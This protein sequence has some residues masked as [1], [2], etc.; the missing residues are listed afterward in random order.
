MAAETT[1]VPRAASLI[2]R[3]LST[4]AA[5]QTSSPL[6]GQ[7]PAEIRSEIFAYVLTDG[8]DHSVPEKAYHKHTCFTRPGYSAPRR[9]DAALLRTCRAAY[10]EGWHLPFA[11]REQV[12]WAVRDWQ[13][14]PPGYD[15][16]IAMHK[17]GLMLRAAR[18]Q[19]GDRET[20]TTTTT[21]TTTAP[22]EIQS[23]R[24]FAQTF[25][26]E[27]GN[28]ARLLRTEDLHPRSLTLT[29]RHAD[30][31][32]WEDDAPLQLEGKWL[33]AV[34]EVLS[35]SV[36]EV[37]VE[38]ES[39]QRKAGQA[40]EIAAQMR[41]KWWFRRADGVEMYAD[42][43]DGVTTVQRW[44]GTSRWHGMRWVRDES[45]EGVIDYYVKTVVFRPVGVLARKGVSVS[46][47]AREF[48][49][50]GSRPL[51]AELK[52]RIN[53]CRRIIHSQP[54]VVEDERNRMPIARR[55]LR[56]RG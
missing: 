5:P 22:F 55:R 20:P 41:D 37:R 11:M 13:R 18:E 14:A 47:E 49:N 23:L 30:W 3:I 32:G 46:P 51:D 2:N 42:E 17:M 28:L 15:F 21:T 54:F 29:V 43:D 40:D 19:R 34:N 56:R 52:L 25:M 50:R 53:E 6:F 27:W 8:P 1:P 12:H 10:G 45:G 31:L 16:E 7:L 24:V 36:R 44:Q 33:P 35:S 48:A 4:P 39:L 38:L 9:T 26:L